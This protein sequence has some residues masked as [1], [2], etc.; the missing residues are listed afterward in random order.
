MRSATR[1]KSLRRV[2]STGAFIEEID[3]LRFFAIF[4]VLYCH[5][6]S[7]FDG[8]HHSFD[9]SLY[10]FLENGANGVR[11][12]FAISGFVLFLPFFDKSIT[13]RPFSALRFYKRRLT[14]LEPPF[15]AAITSYYLIMGVLLHT[16]LVQLTTSDVNHYLATITYTHQLIYGT[17]STI[18][19]VTWSLEVEF[20]FYILVPILAHISHVPTVLR[21]LLLTGFMVLF[22]IRNS[23]ATIVTRNLVTEGHFFAVGILA[24]DIYVN[25]LKHP[26]SQFGKFVLRCPLLLSLVF[27]F[28]IMKLDA[29]HGSIAEVCTF[30]LATLGFMLVVLKKTRSPV[31]AVVDVLSVIGGMCYTIYLYHP[32]LFYAAQKVASYLTLT[33]I[34]LRFAIY[35]TLALGFASI[36]C[37]LL[38]VVFEKP[39]MQKQPF[40]RIMERYRPK[41]TTG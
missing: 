26:D 37:P 17:P 21:R 2:T 12:F 19:P 36:A 31:S 5:I 40:T 35:A 6:A 25:E 9:R 4:A 16:D 22:V 28:G 18:L 29:R 33:S 38:F 27:L 15:I 11:L 34:S 30:L 41:I 24:V 13:A 3:L 8:T 10:I 39:F 23:M 14:R 32:A 20:Q 7:T 1:L